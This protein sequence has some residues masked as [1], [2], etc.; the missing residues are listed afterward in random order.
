MRSFDYLVGRLFQ[1]GLLAGPI[2]AVLLYACIAL[3]IVAVMGSSIW[4]LLR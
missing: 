1:A 2:V 3:M 4:T